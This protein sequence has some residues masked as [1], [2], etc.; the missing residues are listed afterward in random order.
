MQDFWGLDLGN[1]LTI[2]SIIVAY[3]SLRHQQRNDTQAKHEENVQMLTAIR[4]KVEALMHLDDCVDELKAEIGE[5]RR[6]FISF[7]RDKA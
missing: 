3:A 1:L 5:L 4:L 7:L 6:M 2:I